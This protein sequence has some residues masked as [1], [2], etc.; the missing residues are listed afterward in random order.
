MTADQ[1]LSS[2]PA[3]MGRRKRDSLDT[4]VTEFKCPLEH[5]DGKT[6]LA[7]RSI[8]VLARGKEVKTGSVRRVVAVNN[9]FAGLSL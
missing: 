3:R 8:S 2:R 4:W 5:E 9:L 1:Q 6:N 7:W